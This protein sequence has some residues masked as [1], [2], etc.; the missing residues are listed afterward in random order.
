[1]SFVGFVCGI[2][3][4]LEAIFYGN[5][6][7]DAR[8]LM[9]VLSVFALLFGC[10]YAFLAPILIRRYPKYKKITCALLQEYLFKECTDDEKNK[11][12]KNWK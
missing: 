12:F 2:F 1:M 4:L 10:V 6:E 8:I 5:M 7:M 11:K 9:Y 3:F